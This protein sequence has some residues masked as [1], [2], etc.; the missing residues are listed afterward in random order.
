MWMDA[1]FSDA[2]ALGHKGIVC[3]KI[4]ILVSNPE[5]RLGSQGLKEKKGKKRATQIM[6]IKRTI[7]L[8]SS[9]NCLVCI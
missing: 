4:H 6:K 8:I 9:H 7:P 2:H 3:P 1:K 5:P